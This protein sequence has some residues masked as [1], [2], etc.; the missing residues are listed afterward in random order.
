MKWIA[1][2]AGTKIVFSNWA[3]PERYQLYPFISPLYPKYKLKMITET[4]L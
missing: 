3:E 1:G 2:M 4:N